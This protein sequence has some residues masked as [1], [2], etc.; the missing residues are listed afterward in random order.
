MASLL[1]Q[2]V[3]GPRARHPEAGLDLCYV[4]DNIVATSGPSGTYPQLAYRNPLKDL[5]KWLDDQ[6]GAEWCIWEFRAEGT[7]YPDA[8]VYGRVRHYPWPDHHPPPFA[9]VP[10]IVGSMRNWLRGED[11]ESSAGSGEVE[12]KGKGRTVVVHCKAGKGRSGT[13]ACSYLISQEGWTPEQAMQ[14]FTERRM[15]PGFG[16]GIS[17]PSHLRWI[18]YVDRW[19]KGGKVYLERPVEI[20]ELHLWGLRDG[21]KVSVEGF[22]EE[23]K[24]IKNFHTFQKSER[25]IVRGGIKKDKSMADVAL[26][27]VGKGDS[28]GP[29]LD[30]PTKVDEQKTEEAVDEIRKPSHTMT[31]NGT[32]EEGGDIVFRPSSRVVLPSSD[33]NIDFERRNKTKLGGFTMVT[34]VAHVWFNTFFEGRGPEKKGSPDDSGVFEIEWDAMDGLKGSSRKGTRAFDR[35]AVVWKAVNLGG[36]NRK[37]SV[38]IPEPKHGE[39]VK[40][41]TPADWRNGSVQNDSS[42]KNL[43]LRAA[44]PESAAVSRASSTRGGQNGDNNSNGT[45]AANPDDDNDL[46]GIRVHG[47]NGEADVQAPINPT[48]TSFEKTPRSLTEPVAVA[49]TSATPAT[50][51]PASQTDNLTSQSQPT[52]LDHSGGNGNAREE[53]LSR[54]DFLSGKKHVSTEDLPDGRRAS[55]LDTYDEGLLGSVKLGGKSGGE[56]SS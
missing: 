22:I 35:M 55:Q 49:P 52:G 24:V 45:D 17:I 19:T 43:G 39:Q 44:Q 42:D 36:S 20:T 26:E 37:T 14:R 29:A 2:I 6:H 11:G 23:G 12:G 46:E 40:D 16:A 54:E 32:S 30:N 18:T 8:E 56:R 5:V 21:V 28:N 53:V 4:T 27:V 31:L 15:R 10:L 25:E 51:A 50:S 38:P 1:R 7:G 41:A 3:A 34:A 48:K 33:V 13:M 47:P 9:L